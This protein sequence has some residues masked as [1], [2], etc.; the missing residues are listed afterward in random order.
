VAFQIIR[1]VC[2]G[3]IVRRRRRLLIEEAR[4]KVSRTKFKLMQGITMKASYSTEKLDKM[5]RQKL[6]PVQDENA[7]KHLAQYSE[8]LQTGPLKMMCCKV[9]KLSLATGSELA[10]IAEQSGFKVGP[11]GIFELEEDDLEVCQEDSEKLQALFSHLRVIERIKKS[12]A[13][14]ASLAPAYLQVCCLA[15]EFDGF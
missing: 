9:A 12:I 10:D 14:N 15:S 3:G 6:Q 2:H 7:S 11:F 4:A 5:R 13:E 1:A 8:S